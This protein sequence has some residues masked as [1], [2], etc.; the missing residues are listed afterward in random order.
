[1]SDRSFFLQGILPSL[2]LYFKGWAKAVTRGLW[3]AFRRLVFDSAK[4]GIR[5][6]NRE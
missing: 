2:F 4:I 3:N 1:M 5:S 6:D